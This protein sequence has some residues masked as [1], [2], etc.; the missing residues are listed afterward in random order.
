MERRVFISGGTGYM[1]QPLVAALAAAGHSIKALVRPG[2]EGKLPRAVEIVRGNALDASSFAHA[3]GAADAFVHLV[4]VAHPAPWKAQEFRDVDLAALTASA[5]AA[6]SAGV[7]HFVFV[8]VAHPAPAMKAYVR[9]RMECESVLSAARLTST[10]LRPWY[11]LGP[12]HLWPH[13]LRPFYAVAERIPAWHEAALRLGLVTREQ[14]VAALR[15]AVENPPEGTRVLDVTA[16]RALQV[17]GQSS[18]LC[19]EDIR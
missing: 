10:I 3:I 8:S 17:A 9:V 18:A 14:M 11:V 1:G 6:A 15:W 5:E 2:S 19:A 16:I 7:G 4:G 13:A 12:G